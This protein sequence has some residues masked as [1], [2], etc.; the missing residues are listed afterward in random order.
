MDF[1]N[2]LTCDFS[3][4][5]GNWLFFCKL[6]DFVYIHFVDGLIM[7]MAC[8]CVFAVVQTFRRRKPKG[9]VSFWQRA[10]ACNTLTHTIRFSYFYLSLC[11][12]LHCFLK[13]FGNCRENV[14]RMSETPK[15]NRLYRTHTHTRVYVGINGYQISILRCL[16]RRV[17]PL[18]IVLWLIGHGRN[19]DAKKPCFCENLPTTWRLLLKWMFSYFLYK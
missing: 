3:V 12:S 7:N 18:K 15:F 5:N 1:L 19:L 9:R 17:A 11:V 2:G 13:H 10:N 14:R 16:T 4:Y 8:F 6:N